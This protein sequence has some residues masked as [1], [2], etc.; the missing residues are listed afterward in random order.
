MQAKPRRSTIGSVARLTR[1]HHS[2]LLA[3]LDK[4]CVEI[5]C[6]LGRYAIKK[7]SNL[8]LHCST[9]GVVDKYSHL[10]NRPSSLRVNCQSILAGQWFRDADTE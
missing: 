9:Q 7:R 10:V 1:S 5:R 2:V 6:T 3:M 8:S 4:H